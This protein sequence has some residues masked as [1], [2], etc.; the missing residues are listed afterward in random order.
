[1]FLPYINVEFCETDK[2][3][4]TERGS[5]GFESTGRE[6]NV[7]FGGHIFNNKR[8]TIYTKDRKG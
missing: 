4:Y 8:F 2:F 7:V 5:S 3:D 1:M 6:E